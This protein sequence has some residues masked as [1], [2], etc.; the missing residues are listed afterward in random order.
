M[1]ESEVKLYRYRWVVLAAFMLIN[2]M[3][4]V[5]WIS[6]A[7]VASLAATAYH[8]QRQDIDLLA[9]MFML[10]YIL[11][12][13]P[14]AWAID[15]FGFK[16]AVGFGA[17][18]MGVFGLLR[19]L[20][21]TS[22]TAAIIGSIG[23]SIGQPFLLNAFTKL[24]ALWFPQKQRATITGVIFL[25]LFLGIGLGE[26]LGPAMVA[27]YGF[28]GM[29]LIYGVVSAATALIFIVFARSEPPTPASPPGEEVRALVLDSLKQI[30]KN[31]SV[32]VLSLA[33]FIASGIVNGVFTLINGL[34]TELSLTVDQGVILTALLL[35]GG[36]LGSVAIPAV[37]DAIG[38]RKAML[39]TAVFLAVPATLGLV[40]GRGFAFEVICFFVLGFAVTGVTPVAYQYGAEIT[41]PAPEGTS[42]GIFALVVQASG[43]LIVLMDAL[44]GAFHDSYIPSFVG[45]AILL[46][47][48]GFLMFTLIESPKMARA[49]ATGATAE[50]APEL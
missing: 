43:L 9:N 23:I 19:G 31:R 24:A 47:A 11:V 5:L 38:R 36:I 26:S 35:V 37:S 29:Q 33:L 12:A 34:G 4:Q 16:K 8:V 22:Y 46:C 27:S 13:F 3:V 25:A 39:V 2:V 18:L 10:I 21:P 50:P 42:N 41:Y 45:L 1:G 14:A 6:Y 7:P 15:T 49:S 30:L 44:R 17:L 40:L 32:Y 28:G 20:F 48:S